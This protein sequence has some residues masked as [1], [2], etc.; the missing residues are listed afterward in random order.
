MAEKECQK[1]LKL[2]ASSVK[3]YEYLGIINERNEKYEDAA[4]AYLEA[5]SITEECDTAIGYR[6]ACIYFKSK[7]YVQCINT[8]KKVNWFVN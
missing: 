1:I 3:A 7:Q 6:L 2:N 4:D 5:W 8:C